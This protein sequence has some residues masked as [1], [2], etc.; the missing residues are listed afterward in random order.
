[1]RALGAVITAGSVLCL[2]GTSWGTPRTSAADGPWCAAATWTPPGIPEAADQ[3]TIAAGHHVVLDGSCLQVAADLTTEAS[4]SPAAY[5]LLST[6]GGQTLTVGDPVADYAIRN[7]GAIEL[8][9][10]DRLEIDCDAVD[11]ARCEVANVA[12]G[13]FVARGIQLGSGVV[14][15]VYGENCPANSD[16]LPA[17]PFQAANCTDTSIDVD[18]LGAVENGDPRFVGRYIRFAWPSAHRGTWYKIVGASAPSRLTL[19]YN[20]EG[21]Q[22][23]RGVGPAAAT[24]T[25]TVATNSASVT[26]PGGLAGADA[27]ASLGAWFLCDADCPAVS[28][29]S[30]FTGASSE[31]LPCAAARRILDVPQACSSGLNPGTLCPNGTECLG[32]TCSAVSGRLT[33]AS[34]YPTATCADGASARIIGS[35]AGS[36]RAAVDYIERFAVGDPFIVWDP[37]SLTVP[38]ENKQFASVQ[39]ETAGGLQLGDDAVVDLEGVR[40]SFWGRGDSGFGPDNDPI[41]SLLSPANTIGALYLRQV[42][43]SHFGG[44]EAVNY[45]NI[46]NGLGVN[47]DV[48]ARDPLP[49][50]QGEDPS[51]GHG[52][53][54]NQYE[55]PGG[56][57]IAVVVGWRGIRLGDDCIVVNAGSTSAPDSY[58]F[59]RITLDHPTCTFASTLGPRPSAQC[60]D[61]QD[62]ALKVRDGVDILA[63]L[64]SNYHNGGLAWF[65]DQTGATTS[66]R[67]LVS[68]GV[69]Q[70]LQEPCLGAATSA[71]YNALRVLFV[72]SL[73]RGLP[74]GS[75]LS[76]V[77]P[78]GVIGADVF[79][80]YI[81]DANRGIV[82]ADIVKGAFV[83]LGYINGATGLYTGSTAPENFT[84]SDQTYEDVAV[85]RPACP[86]GVNCPWARGFEVGTHDELTSDLMLS[87]GTFAGLST[88]SDGAALQTSDNFGALATV[89]DSVAWNIRD[90]FIVQGTAANLTESNNLFVYTP[91]FCESDGESCPPQSSTTLS[92][93]VVAFKSPATGDLTPLPGTTPF[94]MATS[95]S[96]PAGSRISG[97]SSW[98]RLERVHPPLNA[99]GRPGVRISEYAVDAD[100]DGL[101][102][103]HD[104]CPTVPLQALLFPGAPATCAAVAPGCNPTLEGVPTSCGLG[105]CASTGVCTNGVDTCLLANASVEIC[106]G[107]DND[108]NGDAD[109]DT[110]GDA[111]A[112]CV[113][114]CST[115]ANPSQTDDDSDAVGD[116]CDNCA[117][118]SNADQTDSGGLGTSGADGVGNVCQCGDAHLVS[119]TYDGLVQQD[120]ADEIRAS[121]AGIVALDAGGILKCS[122]IGGPD[123]CDIAD[124]TVLRRALHVPPLA[125]LPQSV[126]RAAVGF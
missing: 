56:D 126:C 118:F 124:V 22:A 120:D 40:I 9:G 109:D 110:D 8:T 28:N 71:D 44:G 4:E 87:H 3:V 75:S 86:T 117:H 51:R 123:D 53:W 61:L 94:T 47:E 78:A 62:A 42:E 21:Q 82:D 49:T 68:D 18:G 66:G 122:V 99:L 6:T 63:P 5:G 80:S 1:M 101:F 85:V 65:T 81:A 57:G 74:G 105:E 116:A 29:D 108:C 12:G 113:D 70:N 96:T 20:S 88:D 33:L 19:D 32:G 25:A 39:D 38:D 83:R 64:C 50:D 72:N 69:F 114:N 55:Y 46:R 119:G 59:A 104:D 31:R 34:G 92:T 14:T 89:R 106:D 36:G 111:V 37:V 45:R 13:Q 84:L 26:W 97:P 48:T 100:S 41:Q 107:L 30:P 112:V 27:R 90:L 60:F 23:A 10:G 73:C 43:I 103:A 67:W 77:A 93:G 24:A 121:L 11:T 95:D 17:A 35:S 76:G 102:D 91:N 16:F 58:D 98:T 15:S 54:I 125:P 52:L 7:A 79:S 2:A 115:V